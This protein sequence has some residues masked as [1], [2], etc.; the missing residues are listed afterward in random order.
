M[1]GVVAE[2]HL[3]PHRHL[4]GQPVREACLHPQEVEEGELRNPQSAGSR[5]AER[6]CQRP[7][8][9]GIAGDEDSLPGRPSSGC[10][11]CP[12]EHC[13]SDRPC[14]EL[15]ETKDSLHKGLF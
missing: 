9:P 5:S 12:M 6:P 2:E 1:I 7:K 15:E 3:P 10:K 4:P 13:R 11:T 14:R 8:W